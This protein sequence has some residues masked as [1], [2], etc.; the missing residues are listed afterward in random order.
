MFLFQNFAILCVFLTTVVFGKPQY[1]NYPERYDS[2]NLQLYY[3][4]IAPGISCCNVPQCS[5]DGC[6]DT[7]VCGY[8]CQN[9]REDYG[10]TPGYK[11]KK[12]YKSQSC[13]FG[14]CN[15]FDFDCSNCPDPTVPEFRIYRVRKSCAYCYER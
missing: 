7:K 15:M 2:Y 5:D 11:I 3:P 6:Y 1:G 13:H 10:P 4:K 14:E 12:S 9:Y 8:L